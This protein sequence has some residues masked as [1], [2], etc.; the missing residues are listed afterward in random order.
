M[1]NAITN[2]PE[3]KARNTSVL[4]EGKILKGGSSELP[5][6]QEFHCEGGSSEL[7]AGQEFHCEGGSSELPAGQDFHCEGG[8][9]ELTA[10]LEVHSKDESEG[11]S[12]GRDAFGSGPINSS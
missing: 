5:A 6:G 1:K 12:P 8:S 4:P 7:P 2:R 10:G 3:T 11:G 9:S